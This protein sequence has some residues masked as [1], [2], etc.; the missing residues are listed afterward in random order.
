ML[1]GKLHR[2]EVAV[3]L[4]EVVGQ[5]F[6]A[7]LCGKALPEFVEPD[8]IFVRADREG[9][10]EP[11]KTA[12]LCGA[13]GIL[14]PQLIT[15]VA[16]R[17]ALA[18]PFQPLC[19]GKKFG[20]GIVAVQKICPTRFLQ[21][22]DLL[23]FALFVLGGVGDVGVIIE[24][25]DGECFLQRFQTARRARPAAAVQKERRAFGQILHKCEH[26]AVAIGRVHA[27]IIKQ[28]RKMRKRRRARRRKFCP[29]SG[30]RQDSTNTDKR[31]QN[32]TRPFTNKCFTARKKAFI[33][34]ISSKEGE[35][36]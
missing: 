25:R 16:A 12:L 6:Y 31:R 35:N 34:Y 28:M 15:F 29:F 17:A 27:F 5:P 33:L 9:G 19:R 7:V 11:T 21:K 20:G 32:K 3:L 8:G 14:Q 22:A 24:H 4:F 1:L 26:F 13:G 23:P 36:T 2:A 30:V 10:A 18:L